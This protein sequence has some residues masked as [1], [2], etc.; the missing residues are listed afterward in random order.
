[1]FRLIAFVFTI[2][3]SMNLM[4][5][6]LPSHRLSTQKDVDITRTIRQALIRERELSLRAQNVSILAEGN[7][8]ILSGRLKNVQE[9]RKVIE[10]SRKNARGKII[11]SELSVQ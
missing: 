5:L 9:L 1:M 8:I 6:G 10:I 2:L 7:E 3:F 4:A 11:R